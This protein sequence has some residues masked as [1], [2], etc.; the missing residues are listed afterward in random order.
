M[1][2]QG[3]LGNE[4]YSVRLLTMADCAE[5]EVMQQQVI[6]DLQD[7]NILQPLSHAEIANIL[8][9]NGIM[10]GAFSKDK[11]IAFRALLDPQDDPEHLGRDGHLAEDQLATVIYQEV[12]TVHPQYRGHGLQKK[13][14][15]II[16]AQ[17][18]TTKY[19]YAC[20]TV[21]PFNIA[22]L[23]DKFSQQMQVVALK[24]KYGGKL[25]YVFMKDLLAPTPNYTEEQWLLMADTEAQQAVL[26]EGYVGI[27]MAQ[28]KEAWYVCYARE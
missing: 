15:E 2:A 12:S 13:L 23:K 14:A 6:D 4:P 17:V 19:R 22:S 9:G 18:D 8:T 16:M 5:I 3:N 26:A 20:A 1:I 11:L 27:A 10:I 21:M 24:Y 25:R 7:K 28:K